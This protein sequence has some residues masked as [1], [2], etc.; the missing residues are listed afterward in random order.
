[1]ETTHSCKPRVA[2]AKYRSGKMY[3]RC[4]SAVADTESGG[5][6]CTNWNKYTRDDIVLVTDS[7]V[8]HSTTYCRCAN[9]Y[10]ARGGYSLAHAVSTDAARAASAARS[11]D[12]VVRR[13]AEMGYSEVHLRVARKA[14]WSSD[15]FSVE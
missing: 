2:F 8:S 14:H 3:R 7:V 6:G 4:S 11:S 9:S 13:G 12:V 1:M 10:V 15:K 5:F